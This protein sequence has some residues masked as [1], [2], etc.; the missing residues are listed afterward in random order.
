MTSERG[1]RGDMGSALGRGP[2]AR[3]IIPVHRDRNGDSG[4][5]RVGIWLERCRTEL[6]S[7]TAVKQREMRRWRMD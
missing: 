5:S 3:W 1:E 4:E 7:V 6:Y 2:T